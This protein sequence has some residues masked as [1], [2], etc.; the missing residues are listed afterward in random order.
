MSNLDQAGFSGDMSNDVLLRG[1]RNEPIDYGSVRDG[2]AFE[3]DAREADRE[4][5]SYTQPCAFY[6]RR[7]G[8]CFSWWEDVAR[9]VAGFGK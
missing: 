5:I 2:Q 9:D 6:D 7:S 4:V 8:L 3:E 1:R